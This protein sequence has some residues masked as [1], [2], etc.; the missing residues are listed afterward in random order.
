MDYAR[1]QT[2]G[3]GF[4]QQAPLAQQLAA[5]QQGPKP[6]TMT[7][8][9]QAAQ[10]DSG[11]VASP[12]DGSG[13]AN[14]LSD[15]LNAYADKRVDDVLAAG[16]QSKRD[17]RLLKMSGYEEFQPGEYR[18]KEAPLKRLIGWARGGGPTA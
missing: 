6:T 8:P 4:L 13:I 2:L 15:A 12:D 9:P 1:F 16:P 5:S 17:E 18:K 11:A 14:A 3:Q 7:P 10:L